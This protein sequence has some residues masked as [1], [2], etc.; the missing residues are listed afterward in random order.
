MGGLIMT[1]V[2]FEEL[3]DEVSTAMAPAPVAAD[4]GFAELVRNPP[5]AANDNSEDW[6]YLPFPPGWTASS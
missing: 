4:A 3:L 1:D 2:E 6:P 5:Q